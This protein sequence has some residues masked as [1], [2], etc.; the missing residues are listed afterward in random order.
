[1]KIKSIFALEILDS[2]GY[3]TL[4]VEVEGVEKRRREIGKARVPSGASRGQY[5]AIEL[6]D[7]DPNRYGGKGVKKAVE[8]VNKTL[9]KILNGI[10]LREVDEIDSYLLEYDKSP[11]KQKIGGNVSLGISLGC[12]KAFAKMYDIPFYKAIRQAFDKRLAPAFRLYDKYDIPTPIFNI[13]NGGAHSDNRIS[14]QEFQV[15][16]KGIKKYSEQLR[17]GSE[18]YHS[19]KNYLRRHGF[20]TGV[21]DEGGFS[22]DQQTDQ[23]VI[24]LLQKAIV[25]AGYI[26]GKQVSIGLDIAISQFY[27]EKDKMYFV[28]NWG[29]NGFYGDSYALAKEYFRWLAKWPILLLEDMFSEEDW[30]GWSEFNALVKRRKIPILVVGDD[31]VVTNRERVEKAVDLDTI[32]AIIVKPNQVG[33]LSETLDTC[34]F[35]R[36]RGIEMIAS[37]RSGDTDDTFISDLAVGIGAN[38]YKG[39]APAR[40]ERETKYNRLLEIEREITG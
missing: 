20:Y 4:Q 33:T 29:R 28:S 3:P 27:R 15:I 1:M 23:T 11:N 19:L 39:G 34:A 2:R 7:N 14:I 12:A 36:Q 10:T 30:V 40:G 13:Y 6:R 8:L 16:P 9:A 32:N 24:E 22:A 5:E 21:G 26:C 18:I 37:H 35:A 31:L 38:Y 25:N 17:A